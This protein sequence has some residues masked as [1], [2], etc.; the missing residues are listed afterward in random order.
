M[1]LIFAVLASNLRCCPGLPD[2][3]V[4]QMPKRGKIYQKT[5]I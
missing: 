2:F 3:F 4:S 1:F 5:A